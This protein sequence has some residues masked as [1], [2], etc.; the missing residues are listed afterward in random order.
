[1]SVFGPNFRH[2][3]KVLI[4]SPFFIGD[5]YRTQLM[6]YFSEIHDK[7]ILQHVMLDHN[8]QMWSNKFLK[9]WK[10]YPNGSEMDS[11]LNTKYVT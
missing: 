2:M 3:R 8:S 4:F 11:I 5:R 7:V 1:M 6:R 10:S 9:N